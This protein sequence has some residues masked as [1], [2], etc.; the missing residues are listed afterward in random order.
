MKASEVLDILQEHY[1]KPI[2][3]RN[4]RGRV[5]P[6]PWA[7]LRELR[8]GTGKVRRDPRKKQPKSIRQRIDAWAYNTWPSQREAISFEIKVSRSDFL[9]ELKQPK[10]REAALA[11]SNRYYFVVV[12]GVVSDLS[13]IPEECGYMI[14]RGNAIAVLK[15]APYRPMADLSMSFISSI[16][17]RISRMEREDSK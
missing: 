5:R 17:R 2:L 11:V 9:H 1:E 7:F 14:T 8:L 16:L 15:E 6:S 13:E 12:D 4:T 10:K 3:P